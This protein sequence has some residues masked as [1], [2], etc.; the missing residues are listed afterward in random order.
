MGESTNA[1]TGKKS[2]ITLDGKWIEIPWYNNGEI[3][4]V[5]LIEDKD[6]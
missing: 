2:I 4:G 6:D 3:L 1:L 5:K